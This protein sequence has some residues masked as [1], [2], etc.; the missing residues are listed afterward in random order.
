MKEEGKRAEPGLWLFKTEPT[1][2]DF[3]TLMRERRTVWDGVS[4]ALALKNLR[5]V[6]VGDRVFC[7]HTGKEKAVVGE[8]TVVGGPRPDPNGDDPKAIVVEVE[9]VRRLP[10]SVTLSVIKEDSQLAGWDL[11]RL[12][13]LSV[14]PLTAAQ[15]RRVEELAET[16]ERGA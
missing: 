14:L 9:A 12:P 10:H 8:M 11:V 1:C 7:Y 2:F 3:D 13:R 5:S 16:G 6:R 15:W 4:N